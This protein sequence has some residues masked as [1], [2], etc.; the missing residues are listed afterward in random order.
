MQHENLQKTVTNFLNVF[1]ANKHKPEFRALNDYLLAQTLSVRGYNDY[2]TSRV[3]GEEF[4]IRDILAPQ[5][6]NLCLDIGANTGGYSRLLLE[7]TSSKV[8]AFEP[9]PTTFMSLKNRLQEFSTR[10]IFENLGLATNARS[11][12]F[13]IMMTQAPTLLSAQM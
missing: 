4:F 6:P 5:K 11:Y 2:Q 10:I 9:L 12:H 7:A 8:I 1:N 13:I 3:T